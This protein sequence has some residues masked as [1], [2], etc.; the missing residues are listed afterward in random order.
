[1]PLEIQ[2]LSFLLAV[3]FIIGPA[4]TYRY[5]LN[6]SRAYFYGYVLAVIGLVVGYVSSH[7][8]LYIAWNLLC[9]FSLALYFKQRM[10]KLVELPT[11]AQAVPVLFSNVAAVWLFAGSNDLY[12][13]GY[14]TEWSYYA[15]LHGNF[16]GW[17]LVG[18]VVLMAR[19]FSDKIAM[20]YYLSAF[21]FLI[22]FLLIAFGIDGV[23]YIKR[24][25]VIG[26]STISPL[27]MGYYV[28]S[29]WQNRGLSFYLSSL[30]LL[31]LLVT[32]Y[33]AGIHQLGLLTTLRLAG[34]PTMVLLH[35]LLNGLLVL[36]CLY[37]AIRFDQR[38][39]Y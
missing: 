35:G 38:V 1:M 18:V 8:E 22:C 6:S 11:L 24:V 25:G 32:L 37:M 26:I 4:M 34:V 27:L 30:G 12:L 20:I 3:A 14:N 29:H 10:S 16:L 33:L 28:F 15:A 2:Y 21:V 31:V 36:P 9:A 19:A 39:R 17:Q 23:P 5:F 7:F 13:L